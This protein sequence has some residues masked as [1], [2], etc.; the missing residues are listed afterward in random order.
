MIRNRVLSVPAVL[1]LT[2]E[3]RHEQFQ[4]ESVA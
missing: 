3:E 1:L 2:D 4:S